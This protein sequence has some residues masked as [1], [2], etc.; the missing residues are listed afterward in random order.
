LTGKLGEIWEL[1]LVGKRNFIISRRIWSFV[2]EGLLLRSQSKL[3]PYYLSNLRCPVNLL[4]N[5]LYWLWRRWSHRQSSRCWLWASW[6]HRLSSRC[7][8]GR[9]LG[10]LSERLLTQ[11][12]LI[13]DIRLLCHLIDRLLGERMSLWHIYMLY[14]P[15]DWVMKHPINSV[16]MWQSWYQN[17]CRRNWLNQRH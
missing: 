9:V 17:L 16:S 7:H 1:I 14:W 6:S 11:N 12:H 15:H 5:H 8:L 2:H 13:V 3:I 4:T 10:N